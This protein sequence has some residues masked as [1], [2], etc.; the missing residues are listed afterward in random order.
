MEEKG[1]LWKQVVSRKFGV[2]EGEWCT[3]KV[4]EG[5]VWGF[6]RKLGRNGV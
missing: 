3:R 2:E 6:G 4:K 5:I 1:T